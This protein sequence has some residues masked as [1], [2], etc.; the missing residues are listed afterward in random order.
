MGDTTAALREEAE[1]EE[2]E[3]P[4]GLSLWDVH[5]PLRPVEPPTATVRVPRALLERDLQCPVCLGVLRRTH[6]AMGC[7]HRF[8]GDCIEKCLRVAKKECP[9]C[10]R[11]LPSRRVLRADAA[12]DALVAALLPASDAAARVEAQEM[13]RVIAAARARGAALL[14]QQQSRASSLSSR[15]RRPPTSDDAVAPKR[16]KQQ[17]QQQQRSLAFVLEPANDALPSL[18]CPFVAA[19]SEAVTVRGVAQLL[20]AR[21]GKPETAFSIALSCAPDRPLDHSWKLGDLRRQRWETRSGDMVLRFSFD[22]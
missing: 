1:R 12:A 22:A 2:D 3:L 20:A 16:Q 7:L 9:A 4:A 18:Q 14:E 5:R 11:P 21:L 15:R 6:T 8:C 19:S 10:R 13:A 17:Q